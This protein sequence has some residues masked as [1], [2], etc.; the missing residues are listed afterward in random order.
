LPFEGSEDRNETAHFDSSEKSSRPGTR[1]WSAEPRVEFQSTRRVNNLLIKAIIDQ[2]LVPA[3]VEEFLV[4]SG[5]ITLDRPT[6]AIAE[7][8][9]SVVS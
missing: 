2:W 7:H 5:Y 8:T 1:H 6:P 4:S 9:P 3:M